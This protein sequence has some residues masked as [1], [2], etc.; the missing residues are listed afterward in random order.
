LRFAIL[1]R[2]S[3]RRRLQESGFCRVN[4]IRPIPAR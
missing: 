2:R 1:R 4:F 3:S